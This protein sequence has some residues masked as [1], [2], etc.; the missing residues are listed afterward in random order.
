M[1]KDGHLEIDVDY[2]VE[3]L[4]HGWGDSEYITNSDGSSL[5]TL[6][7]DDGQL[8]SNRKSF[9]D[10]P[11]K[12]SFRII[13]VNEA[14]AILKY[15]RG[16]HL[17]DLG[18]ESSERVFTA[19]LDQN[20]GNDTWLVIDEDAKNFYCKFRLYGGK[21]NRTQILKLNLDT[22][23]EHWYTLSPTSRV[24]PGSNN[25]LIKT[26][27]MVKNKKS[28]LSWAL[29]NFDLNVAESNGGID[30]LNE[31]GLL[32]DV[33]DIKVVPGKQAALFR[34]Y[35]EPVETVVYSLSWVNGDVKLIPV[36]LEGKYSIDNS[37]YAYENMV[38]SPDGKHV[39]LH[40]E[41]EKKREF[42]HELY[43]SPIEIVDGKLVTYFKKVFSTNGRT[44][45]SQMTWSRTSDSFMALE[46]STKL[47]Y[48]EV[49]DFLK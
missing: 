40:I 41:Y 11:L 21:E 38:V 39:I 22:K 19:D 25:F 3:Y 30:F 35:I 1:A 24:I 47:H 14:Q 31:K 27:A 8:K 12:S 32:L 9:S 18:S 45:L 29:L 4:T 37:T 5:V 13:Q 36:V 23:E 46:Q 48:W 20:S 15:G 10:V 17:V 6:K 33:G 2:S 42:A 28:G 49:T 43:Y 7:I 34:Y 44:Y 26:Y 16:F